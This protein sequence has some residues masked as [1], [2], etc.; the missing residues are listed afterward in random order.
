MRRAR[1]TRTARRWN[2]PRRSG[3][4]QC[5]ACGSNDAAECTERMAQVSGGACSRSTT[6]R[7]HL[8]RSDDD[9]RTLKIDASTS[10][11]PPLRVGVLRGQHWYS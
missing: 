4:V 3:L 7:P 1:V 8:I 10:S 11:L 2:R 6:S 5:D 9:D